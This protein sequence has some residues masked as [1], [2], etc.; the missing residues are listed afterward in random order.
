VA[1]GELGRARAYTYERLRQFQGAP[2][3]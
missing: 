3:C 2:D 1:A